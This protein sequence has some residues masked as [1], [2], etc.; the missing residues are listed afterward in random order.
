MVANV[1][2]TRRSWDCAAPDCSVKF[3]DS[4]LLINI[5]L[6][7][8]WDCKMSLEL[9]CVVHKLDTRTE[10]GKEERINDA[11]KYKKGILQNHSSMISEVVIVYQGI[12]EQDIFFISYDILYYVACV[13]VCLSVCVY[14]FGKSL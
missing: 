3:I 1:D 2:V 10:E 13:H 8:F 11:K 7:N 4:H 5:G 9:I 14:F 6:N 12:N